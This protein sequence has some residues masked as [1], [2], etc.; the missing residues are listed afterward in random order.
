M[1][2]TAIWSVKGNLGRVVDYAANPE[3]TTY[4][5]AE[6]Q[7][8]R[9]VM[10]YATQ[11]YKT[12]EQRYVSGVNCAPEI[13]R[14]QMLL[15]KRQFG[16]EGGVI[17]FHGY[18]SF[19]PGEVTPEQA[20][21]IGVELAKRL[22]GDRFQVVVATHLDRAH[23]HNH[24][25]LNS[26][27]FVDGKKYNDC[28]A[29]YALMR[30]AS[31]ELCREHGLSVIEQPE[32]GGMSYDAWEAE[33]RGKPTWYGQI[34][35]DV[36]ACIARAFLF[37]HFLDNLK[38]QGYEVK[39]GKYLAVRPPGKARFVRLKTLGGDYA[40]D[41]I[42]R[43]IRAQKQYERPAPPPPVARQR[44]QFRGKVK[45][46]TGFRA[47]YYH[48]LYLLRRLRKPTAQPRRSRAM[49]DE[50]IKFDR[51]VEQ[52]KLLTKYRIDTDGQLATLKEAVRSELDALTDERKAL[53]AAKR[54]NPE[55]ETLSANL[56]SINQSIKT[57]RR[58]L[59]VCERIEASI[60]AIRQKLNEPAPS[61]Q[62]TKKPTTR[63]H[64]RTAWRLP[65]AEDT[66]PIRSPSRLK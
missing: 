10:N 54:R 61:P 53:Y 27:S 35:R 13:A 1:A 60:P 55:E 58:E 19:A 12:E 14:E 50:I 62:E 47:L 56:L 21:E 40:E 18:Q 2:T 32:R 11:D 64:Q 48:Y 65:H 5:P 42:R 43:R 28:K 7:G 57:L 38:R 44:R 29:S 16:K 25:V 23:L 63:A 41:A 31:D 52:A 6:L 9:D 39:T 37:E 45:K 3:K 59:R 46:L 4:S 26:V 51:Y 8:L 30:R 33:Q 36:D 15:V 49:M 20:H 22:W 66:P 34:R 17:A 24:F